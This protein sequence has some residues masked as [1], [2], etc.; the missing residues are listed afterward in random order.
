MKII[1]IVAYPIF[2]IVTILFFYMNIQFFY[3]K[4]SS[5]EF[6]FFSNNNPLLFVNYDKC[7]LNSINSIISNRP[8][9]YFG[10][11][12]EQL[13][14]SEEYSS[15]TIFLY[16]GNCGH[17][18]IF[19]ETLLNNDKPDYFV[20]FPFNLFNIGRTCRTI[21]NKTN[22]ELIRD[23]ELYNFPASNFNNQKNSL[24]TEWQD[25]PS[26][27]EFRFNSSSVFK[28]VSFERLSL[29]LFISDK[30]MNNGLVNNR[31]KEF[32]VRFLIP[33]DYLIENLEEINI[34]N[35]NNNKNLIE[36]IGKLEENKIFKLTIINKNYEYIKWWVN[37]IWL[38]F[39]SDFIKGIFAKSTKSKNKKLNK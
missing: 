2:F 18:T 36:V 26:I 33:R 19:N 11:T 39:I 14:R 24:I 28:R 37:T 30:L 34:S 4:D 10:C 17:T 31:P 6:G 27:I 7:E 21:I 13:R 1:N 25:K 12:S 22:G 16:C 38:I 32:I 8:E 20:L 5:E 35:S 15:D 29:K 9:F 3:E 23:V